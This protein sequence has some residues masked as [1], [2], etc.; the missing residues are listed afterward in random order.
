MVVIYSS[1]LKI[2]DLTGVLLENPWDLISVLPEKNYY[3]QGLNSNA[4]FSRPKTAVINKFQ[5]KKK[6]NNDRHLILCDVYVQLSKRFSETIK[7]LD[8]QWKILKYRVQFRTLLIYHE[9]VWN[10]TRA[11]KTPRH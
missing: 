9:N 10:M 1:A 8:D 6:Y 5:I 7:S 11:L 2:P 4:N 3:D